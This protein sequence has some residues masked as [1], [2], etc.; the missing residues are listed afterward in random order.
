M[1]KNNNIV[2]FENLSNFP[3]LI[4]GFSTRPF[5]SMR[6]SHLDSQDAL[7]KFANALKINT[8]KIVRMHQV[9]SNVVHWVTVNNQDKI[10]DRTDGLLTKEQQIFLGV[11]TGDCIPLLFYDPSQHIVAAVH[12]GWRGLFSEIIK[13]TVNSF[14]AKGSNASDILVGIGPCIRDCCYDIAQ[15]HADKLLTKFPDWKA[16]ITEREKKLFLNLPGVTI[17]QLRGLG[18][19]QKNIEDADYCTFD[20]EDV[21]SYRREGKDFGEMM[22]IIGIFT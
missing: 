21:Y 2:T 13:E 22:G 5:G 19:L 3:S 1:K 12:A 15:D 6:P 14:V 8:Q 9:H 17:Y 18:V 11:V 10:I 16:F 4:H 7:K 20:H